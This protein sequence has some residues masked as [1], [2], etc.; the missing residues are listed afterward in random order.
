M[1]Y[2]MIRMTLNECLT[3]GISLIGTIT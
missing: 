1:K 2:T 3:T